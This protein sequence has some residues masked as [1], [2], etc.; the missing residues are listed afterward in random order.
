MFDLLPLT[1]IGTAVL[2]ITYLSAVSAFPW[3]ADQPEVD[4][5]LLRVRRQQPG[6]GA[7]GAATCPSNPNH[8]GAA[9]FN[10]K[11]PYNYAQNGLPGKGGGGY[12]V[13]AD[14]DTAHQYVSAGA[15]DIRGPCPGLNTLANH[16]VS[17]NQHHG[18][19]KADQA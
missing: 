16:N 18:G 13:P 1:T 5:S 7:G 17:K 8:K 15:L 11:Y 19:P 3:V 9:P 2:L 12:K 4:S 6:S 10:P 14:G